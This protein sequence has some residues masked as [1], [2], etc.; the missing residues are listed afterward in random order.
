MAL[1]TQ[2]YEAFKKL[3]QDPSIK[4]ELACR[5]YLEHAEHLLVRRTLRNT[6]RFTEIRSYV[7][8]ADLVV[9]AEITNDNREPETWAYF[10][11][12]KAP[13]CFL[14]EYDD[15][16]NRCRPTPDLIKAENQLLHYVDEAVANENTRKRLGVMD[17][18]NIR[19]GGIIIGTTSTMLRAAKDR[20]DVTKATAA[21]Q[22]RRERLYRAEEIRI[23]TWDHIL[24]EVKPRTVIQP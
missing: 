4:H 18:K 13:Q 17:S 14:F 20:H 2:E 15:N 9:V 10:W 8:D 24:D 3:V 21:L 16:K 12:L 1:N 11:E 7:G 6:A 22:L 23:V 19:P 5:P